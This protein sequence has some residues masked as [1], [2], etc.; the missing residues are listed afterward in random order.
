MEN[1]V[2]GEEKEQELFIYFCLSNIKYCQRNM[3]LH[4]KV[5]KNNTVVRLFLSMLSGT[6]RRMSF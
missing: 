4:E 5:A 3:L 6:L 2:Q 1:N